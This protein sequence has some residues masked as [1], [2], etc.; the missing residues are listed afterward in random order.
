M[1]VVMAKTGPSGQNEPVFQVSRSVRWKAVALPAEHGGW[2]FLAEPAVLGLVLS[3]SA[4][5]A[6]L[7]LAAL[8]GFLAR[9]PLRLLLIDRRNGVRYPRTALA[10]RVFAGYAGMAALLLAVAT[11][12]AP[13]PFW[14]P[15][16][17][18]API[19]LV[20]LGFDALG[21]NREALPEV[22]GA[23][24]LGSSATAIALAGE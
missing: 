19:G 4:A 24:A 20:A 3:P 11:A 1:T 10:E 7:A 6:C 14:L 13:A 18:A 5:G 2:S 9:H 21:R 16:L 17:V 15:L 8:A 12:L 22:A 23:V